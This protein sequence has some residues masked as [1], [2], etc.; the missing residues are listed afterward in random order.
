MIAGP[1]IG[2]CR[3]FFNW[4]TW[5]DGQSKPQAEHSRFAYKAYIKA[6][7]VKA[8]R[9]AGYRPSAL[10]RI[11]DHEHGPTER[12]MTIGHLKR[13]H[14]CFDCQFGMVRKKSCFAAR[15]PRD[16]LHRRPKGEREAIGD[17]P[18]MRLRKAETPATH[19]GQSVVGYRRDRWAS[20]V[21]V[22]VPRNRRSA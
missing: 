10:K 21:L 11:V 17:R 18:T 15:A 1:T 2:D 9:G 14:V 8:K 7:S 3:T 4:T 13:K 5:F 12:S 19:Y 22:L 16:R 6:L 20:D